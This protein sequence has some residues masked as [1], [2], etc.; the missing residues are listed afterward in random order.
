MPSAKH[1]MNP[2]RFFGRLYPP[3]NSHT[4]VLDTKKYAEGVIK[5]TENID[6][7]LLD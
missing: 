2:F 4:I 7:I 5:L 6:I 1:V 3:P